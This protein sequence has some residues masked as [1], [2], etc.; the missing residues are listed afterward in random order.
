[1]AGWAKLSSPR[2]HKLRS[3]L[4][5]LV[6]LWYAWLV[7][8]VVL[9]GLSI[10]I[11]SVPQSAAIHAL[12][13]G[14]TGTMILAVMTRVAAAFAE[15]LYV[16][17]LIFSAVCWIAAFGGFILSYGPM[18]MGSQDPAGSREARRI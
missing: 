2:E 16:P 4:E 3:A 18:L 13:A 7:A 5:R 6:L 17:L 11:P 14:A 15:Q 1:M 8:G 10:L 12:T 9:L